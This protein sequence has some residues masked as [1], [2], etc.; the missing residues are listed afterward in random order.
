MAKKGVTWKVGRLYHRAREIYSFDLLPETG[1]KMPAFTNLQQYY[2]EEYLFDRARELE[3]RVE[4]RWKNRVTRVVRRVDGALIEVETPDGRYQL[5][6]STC[7]RPAA[8]GRQRHARARHGPHFQE[9]FLITDVVTPIEL[10]NERRFWSSRRSTTGRA[11][12]APP[13]G[14]HVSDRP[15]A[16][17]GRRPRVGEA[18]E[19]VIRG[20]RRCS[21]KHALQSSGSALPS[22]AAAQRFVHGRVIFIGDS[23]RVR[24]SARAAATA[25]SGRRQP[26]LKLALVLQGGRQLPCSGPMMRAGTAPTRTSELRPLD[27]L[28][29][30]QGAIERQFRTACWRS[31]RICRSR[32]AGQLRAPIG[33]LF[34]RAPPADQTKCSRGLAR[35]AVRRRAPTRADGR[36]A[37]CSE[38]LGG[39]FGLRFGPECETSG[40]ARARQ[41]ASRAASGLVNGQAAASTAGVI[42]ASRG[43]VRARYGGAPGVT[44]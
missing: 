37:G 36:R 8:Q 31:P 40:S 1:H 18:A 29:G 44:Y 23:A 14:Q 10:P 9:R 22:G 3:D 27:Q 43:L 17:V 16:R 38:H 24:R 20:S 4:L 35:R 11:G 42:S 28:H 25:A 26:G 7:S 39:V 5:D 13:A 21:A 2:A 33:A 6:A 32:A 34:A 12:S 30:A 15:A 19:R 41:P